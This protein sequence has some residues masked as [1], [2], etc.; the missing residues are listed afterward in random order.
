MNSRRK[1]LYAV[2]M[3]FGLVCGTGHASVITFTKV[4]SSSSAING[5]GAGTFSAPLSLT[6]TLS[7]FDSSLGTLTQVSWKDSIVNQNMNWAIIRR[8]CSSTGSGPVLW[9]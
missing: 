2:A 6:M 9:T 4:I 3:M 8:S 1:V 5:T 7:Q